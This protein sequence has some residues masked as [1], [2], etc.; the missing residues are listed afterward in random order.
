M[1]KRD[2]A[3]MHRRLDE[4]A[5]LYQ[6]APTDLDRIIVDTVTMQMLDNPSKPFSE[7]PERSMSVGAS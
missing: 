1:N 4:R 7:D 2:V 6:E 3:R 5:K